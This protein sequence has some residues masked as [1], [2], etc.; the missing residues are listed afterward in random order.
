MGQLWGK[1]PSL[2]L[3]QLSFVE[4]NTKNRLQM[5]CVGAFLQSAWLGPWDV[6]GLAAGKGTA[7]HCEGGMCR[8]FSPMPK[9][10]VEYPA[11]S[12]MACQI[13]ATRTRTVEGV[14]IEAERHLPFRW[15][16]AFPSLAD[17]NS[18]GRESSSSLDGV[19]EGME[20][21]AYLENCP[22]TGFCAGP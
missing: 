11:S 20:S 19:S 7:A 18:Q 8:D 12:S 4:K 14:A 21:S 22:T 1:V 13:R 5:A 16:T 3:P 10:L 6:N 9:R 17:R 2:I 15:A